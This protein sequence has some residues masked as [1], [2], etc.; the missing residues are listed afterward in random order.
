[1]DTD[2]DGMQNFPALDA[3]VWAFRDIRR[4][5]TAMEA[6]EN[7][8]VIHLLSMLE[9]CK[10]SLGN[11]SNGLGLHYSLTSVSSNSTNEITSGLCRIM[12][13]TLSE[14]EVHG[15]WVTGCI[16][17]PR[18][19]NLSFVRD[20][21]GRE[22]YRKVGQSAIRDMMKDTS[23]RMAKEAHPDALDEAEGDRA[24]MRMRRA[25]DTTTFS[26]EDALDCPALEK[27]QGDEL[28]QFMKEGLKFNTAD[29]MHADDMGMV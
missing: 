15:V 17:H 14:I 7:H 21:A 23:A 20:T 29:L 3:I 26:L 1:V 12:P 11:L 28:S 19:R 10:Q 9:H 4:M 25:K 18:L 16:L 24:D 22:Q 5:Q 27:I 13:T 2:V 8:T 6:S